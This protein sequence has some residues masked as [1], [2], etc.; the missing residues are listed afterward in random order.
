M[1]PPRLPK[2]LA[3]A[4]GLTKTQAKRYAH[5]QEVKAVPIG[6]PPKHL[7]P[8]IKVQWIALCRELPWLA[9]SDAT[10]VEAVAVLRS[11]LVTEGAAMRSAR[12]SL[13]VKTLGQ[14]GASPSARN[15]VKL[16]PTEDEQEPT[17]PYFDA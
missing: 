14:L 1:A 12:L 13:L 4:K 2:A 17:K 6:G 5:R 9:A 8:A 15:S 10:L 3:E 11:E 7:T 16:L